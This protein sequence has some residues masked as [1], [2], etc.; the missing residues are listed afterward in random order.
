[1]I[2]S[3]P[4]PPPGGGGGGGRMRSRMRRSVIFTGHTRWFFL[5]NSNVRKN[6]PVLIWPIILYFIWFSGGG[7]GEEGRRI[8]GQQCCVMWMGEG[9][10]ESQWSQPLAAARE[11]IN[12]PPLAY[13]HKGLTQTLISYYG[14]RDRILPPLVFHLSLCFLPLSCSLALCHTLSLLLCHGL[15]WESWDGISENNQ[16]RKRAGVAAKYDSVAEAWL[17][18]WW[19]GLS[20][21]QNSS[22][23]APHNLIHYTLTWLRRQREDRMILISAFLLK[24]KSPTQIN[25][26]PF[27]A[28]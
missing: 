2:N 7:S 16:T 4:P 10:L 19:G 18:I 6:K 9:D 28:N 25:N 14:T 8:W 24:P 21:P 20:K 12:T 5:I 3:S 22:A 11:K 15:T 26:P 13:L 17:D 1:M 27:Q 23:L